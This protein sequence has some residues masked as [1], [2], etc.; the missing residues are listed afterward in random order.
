MAYKYEPKTY[1]VEF[2][3]DD[4]LYGLHMR[5]KSVKVSEFLGIVRMA[6]QAQTAVQNGEMTPELVSLAAEATNCLTEAFAKSLIEWDLTDAEGTPIPATVEAVRELDQDFM[7]LLMEHWMQV[8]GGASK[9]LG[10]GSP[11]GVTSPAVPMPM[12]AL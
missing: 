10:K 4:E 9:S 6:S 5:F 3:T 2:D 7:S 12:E 8:V 11:S 1:S